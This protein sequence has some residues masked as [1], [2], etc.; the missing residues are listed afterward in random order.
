MVFMMYYKVFNEYS[1]GCI[2]I[3]FIFLL[4]SV[5]VNENYGIC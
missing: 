3:W 2:C 1:V 4:I 5:I